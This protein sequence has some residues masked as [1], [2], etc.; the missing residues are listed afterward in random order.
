M[1]DT[2][3]SASAVIRRTSPSGRAGSC[4]KP[5]LEDRYGGVRGVRLNEARKNRWGHR[6]SARPDPPRRG[7]GGTSSIEA[8]IRDLLDTI[9]ASYASERQYAKVAN[10]R[11]EQ[12]PANAPAQARPTGLAPEPGPKRTM[13]RLT[14]HPE[15][16]SR[17]DR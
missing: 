8:V 13:A 15:P 14:A 1:P 7:A 10:G 3:V 12:P 6:R 2:P 17:R 9:I 11:G 16:P 5:F 4:D